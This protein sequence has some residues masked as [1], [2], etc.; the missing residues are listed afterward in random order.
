MTEEEYSQA[1]H[2]EGKREDEVLLPER[3]N[4]TAA[5]IKSIRETISRI[6]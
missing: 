2:K 4:Y 5:N 3:L 6:W 1:L